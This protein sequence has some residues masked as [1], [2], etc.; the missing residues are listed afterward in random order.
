MREKR[1]ILEIFQWNDGTS[2]V[3]VFVNRKE[4]VKYLPEVKEWHLVVETDDEEFIDAW[5]VVGKDGKDWEDGKDWKDY[6]LTNKDKEEIAREIP[7]PIVEKVI[8]KREIIKE[9][10]IITNE[11]KEVAKHETP[12]Q[13]VKKIESLEWQER[14]SA[15]AIKWLEA[16]MTEW[17][18]AGASNL[19]S[20]TD[21]NIVNPNNWQILVYNQWRSQRENTNNSSS[22]PNPT[23]GAGSSSTNITYAPQD[24][25]TLYHT[26][27][28]FVP[29]NVISTVGTTVTTVAA[30]FTAAMVGSKLTINGENRIITA[31]TSATQVTVWVAY[32]TNYTNVPSPNWWV[33]SKLMD[34]LGGITTFYTITWLSWIAWS[35]W[36]VNSSTFA[37]WGGNFQLWFSWLDLA[38]SNAIRFSNTTNHA[39]SKDVWIRRNNIGLI[40]IYDGVTNGTLR[41]LTLR[42]ILVNTTTDNWIDKLQV[43]G[44]IGM[45]QSWDTLSNGIT[46]GRSGIDRGSIWLNGTNNTLNITR[47][48]GGV[49]WISIGPTGFIGINIPSAPTTY[50]DVEWT[51]WPL[52]SG[53][54]VRLVMNF[55]DSAAWNRWLSLG[56]D[57]ISQTG[58]IASRWVWGNIAFW[59]FDSFWSEKMRL[60]GNGNLGIG[61]TAP[62]TKL[63]VVVTS[64]D[65]SSSLHGI[66]VNSGFP[67][68]PQAIQLGTNDTGQYSW[69][70]SR[71]QGISN[72]TLALNP[73]GGN[74]G[75]GISNPDTIFTVKAT[76]SNG[77]NLTND[78][79]DANQSARLFLSTSTAGQSVV[80]NNLAGSMTFRTG[81]TAGSSSGAVK[82]TLTNPGNLW[83]WWTPNANAILDLQSTTK[84]FIP[85]KMTT[86]QKNAIPSPT[87]WMMVYDTTLNKLCVYTTVWETVTSV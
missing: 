66:R 15:N 58:V 60:S 79:G 40:E 45:I 32:S 48:A 47:G 22:L 76:G 52:L 31:F 46:I 84:A 81:G 5:N 23:T 1:D 9:V 27:R 38:T 69:I 8:E 62:I 86:T 55:R 36:I 4:I 54:N 44:S 17:P 82:M 53:T 63:D 21:T 51:A 19:T 56:Y 35:G 71:Q 74:V 18:R 7:V 14:L 57:S 85:P 25:P 29:S 50:L 33:Y 87:A 41:D 28:W 11:I 70:Q 68:N 6:I 20:L 78:T 43:N 30:Q 42:K 13:I 12:K 64:S 67:I 10:P 37:W 83:I 24:N 65:W 26:S 80:I 16:F 2:I 77:I 61:W 34:T 39:G 72:T 49:S 73:I 3:D 59:T 75:V